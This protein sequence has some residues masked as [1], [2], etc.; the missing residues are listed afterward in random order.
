[1]QREQHHP[2]AAPTLEVLL[3]TAIEAGV[4]SDV[5]DE[6]RRVTARAFGLNGRGARAA[7]RRAE[8]YF[9]GVI[10]R[11]ALRGGAPGVTQKLV[12]AS[13][14]QELTA[15]GHAPEAVLA[16]VERLHGRGAAALIGL[17][18]PVGGRAA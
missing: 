10:R 17:R 18:D 14:A 3:L 8:H 12:I 9:W 5:A 2:V 11:R 16:E 7:T 4:P 15:A 13:L 1:M 6:A